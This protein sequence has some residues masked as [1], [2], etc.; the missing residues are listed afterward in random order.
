MVRKGGLEP[1]RP[2]GHKLLRLTRLP[3]RHFRDQIRLRIQAVII[4]GTATGVKPKPPRDAPR[5]APMPSSRSL[6]A[7][8]AGDTLAARPE[9]GMRTRS[10]LYAGTSVPIVFFMTTLICGYRLGGYDHFSRMVSELGAMGTSSRY[11]FSAGLIAC[12][13]LSLFFVVGLWKACQALGLSPVPALWILS[14]SVSIAGAAIFPLPLRM[15]MIMGRPSV[16]MIL[17]PLTGFILWKGKERPPQIELMSIVCFLVMSLGFL[18][19]MPDLLKN[20]AG[21]KQRFFHLGWSIWFIYLSLAFVGSLKQ[22]YE[23]LP[24]PIK[25]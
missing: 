1:P 4:S 10:L 23:E 7:R 16:L 3:F 2:Y 20:A 5:F 15:H 11:V 14:F 19:F 17:S 24:A 12:S 22:R 9:E 13:I 25:P 21:L 8:P 18:A 6:T